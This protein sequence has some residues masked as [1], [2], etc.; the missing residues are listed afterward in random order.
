MKKTMAIISA[1]IIGIGCWPS[2]TVVMAEEAGDENKS[3]EY[4]SED[5][6]F[7]QSQS[8]FEAEEKKA[9]K[10]NADAEKGGEENKDLVET[11]ESADNKSAASGM[12]NLQIP[13]KMEIVIDPWEMDGRGQIYS[14]TYVIKNRGNTTGTLTLSN[15]A[16]KPGE[17]SGVI[18][19]S[20]KDG[21]HDN[22]E[23]ALYMEM[24]FGDSDYIVMS[25]QGAEYQAELK[26]EE[27]LT[28]RFT[29]E[30][31]ENTSEDWAN[32]NVRVA[33]VIYSW[34]MEE[35]SADED[36]DDKESAESEENT[37]ERKGILRDKNIDV[38][39]EATGADNGNKGSGEIEESGGE[40]K[41]SAESEENTNEMKKPSGDAAKDVKEEANGSDNGGKDTGK[42]EDS[43]GENIFYID[44]GEQIKDGNMQEEKKENEIKVIELLEE[45][46][47]K[48]VIDFLK[49]KAN[50]QIT[51]PQ[52]I[53]RN[54]GEKTGI[55]SLKNIVRLSEEGSEIAVK[56][57]REEVQDADE[58]A[59]FVEMV[60][61]NGNEIALTQTDS[62][63]KLELGPGEDVVIQFDGVMN[64]EMS[65]EWEE[66]CI[67]IDAV[68]SW[69]VEA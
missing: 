40:S 44:R 25:E 56:A 28:I 13:Q 55:L 17:S 33:S 12:K 66:G 11:I 41:E 63:Y 34:N 42:M 30:V 23:K 59:V 60:L 29:G 54:G 9:V 22:E 24:R 15:L 51:S 39:E 49:M 57:V 45:Q 32:V 62:E 48:A 26:P 1:L 10:E 43:S 50:Y 7:E 61:G 27:E 47:T 46:E 20:N 64:E 4:L 18:V 69:D 31:N 2:V 36:A 16:C 19:R 14:E 52:F 37:N 53:I 5:Y 3:T 68:Y 6:F 58:K 35:I 67:V 21:L 65:E 38:E 8:N